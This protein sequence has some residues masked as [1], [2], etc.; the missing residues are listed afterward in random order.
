MN[1]LREAFREYYTLRAPLIF[2]PKVERREVMLVSFEGVVSRHIAVDGLQSLRALL[3]REAPRH[4]YYSVGLY[5]R[6][7]ARSMSE[8]GLMGAELLFD[9]DADHL[10]V[11]E[12]DEGLAWRCKSCGRSGEGMPPDSCPECGSSE[13]ESLDWISEACLEAAKRETVRLL[14][15]VLDDLGVSEESMM[16]Y[17]TGHRGY[18]I[19]V[20]SEAVLGLGKDERRELASHI[21]GRSFDPREVF[22]TKGAAVFTPTV[23][24]GGWRGRVARFLLDIVERTPPRWV[25]RSLHQTLLRRGEELVKCLR[26]GVPLLNPDK[27]LIKSLRELAAEYVSREAVKIDEMVTPDTTRLTRIPN[28]LHGKT[29]LRAMALS[30]EELERFSPLRDAVGLGEDP[31]KVRV[32]A[33]VPKFTIKGEWY[34]P[35][36]EGE[37]VELPTYAAALV[38]L[39]GR[40]VV[41]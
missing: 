14:K 28:S 11:P 32:T 26:D 18:H 27:R 4:A 37:E 21:I 22:K 40:G 23:D 41:S 6:P 10:G 1:K 12:C 31:L 38:V 20:L 34:G 36:A 17:Y 7:S 24:E 2:V 13:L 35:F 19:R 16:I 9:I 5:E 39:K 8:K 25:D 15:I 29:G 3:I 33:P 30:L